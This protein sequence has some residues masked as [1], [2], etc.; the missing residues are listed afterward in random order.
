MLFV[1]KLDKTFIKRTGAKLIT[2][3]EVNTPLTDALFS[4]EKPIK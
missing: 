2:R 4:C 3:V 1:G